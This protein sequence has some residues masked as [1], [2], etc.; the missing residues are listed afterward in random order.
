MV[1]ERARLINLD[2]LEQPDTILRALRR[3]QL[4]RLGRVL[5]HP[6][7]NSITNVRLDPARMHHPHADPL[8]LERRA[9]LAREHVERGLGD[10]VRVR[11]TGQHGADL[12]RA[13][14]RRYDRD[15][16]VL[17]GADEGEEGAHELDRVDGV[18]GE[19]FGELVEVH[20]FEGGQGLVDDARV[21]DEVVEAV[22]Q[23]LAG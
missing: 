3:T 9:P 19:F 15:A 11:E 18:E 13:Q 2:T 6:R 1:I 5:G 17:A 7:A 22:G 14:L 4:R 12:D 16:L 10:G 21:A 23:D 8:E 20:F